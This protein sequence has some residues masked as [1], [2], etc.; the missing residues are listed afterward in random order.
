MWGMICAVLP[1]ADVIAFRFGIPYS[2]LFGHR[3]ITHSI[4][5]A[6]FFA[7]F[8]ALLFF[9][10]T[11][12]FST[13]WWRTWFYLFLCTVSHGIL[14]AL[15]TG[16]LGVAFFAPFDN[17]RYF[18]PDEYRR[19]LVSPIGAKYFFGERGI[20]VLK[21]EFVWVWI[22]CM[23]VMLVGFIKNRLSSSFKP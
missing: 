21:S 8:I 9:R 22:P 15:T 10:K 19:L 20:R 11:P 4:L 18:F 12:F 6:V 7:A 17:S 2:H 3:G 5:F 1:D 14:D 23:V 13:N 16:G